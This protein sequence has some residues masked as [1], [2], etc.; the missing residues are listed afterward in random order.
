MHLAGMMCRFSFSVGSFVCLLFV[1]LQTGLTFTV[2]ERGFSPEAPLVWGAVFLYGL[3]ASAVTN[4]EVN[5]DRREAKYNKDT[6]VTV[7]KCQAI[8]TQHVVPSKFT[9][10]SVLPGFGNLWFGA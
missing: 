5:G 10:F 1:C 7:N 8:E 9:L 6:K 4:L 2:K 3:D